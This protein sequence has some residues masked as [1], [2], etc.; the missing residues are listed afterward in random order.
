MMKT[1]FRKKTIV[2][3]RLLAQKLL[4]KYSPKII[5]ITGAVGKTSTREACFTVLSKKFRCVKNYDSKLDDME[6]IPIAIVGGKEDPHGWVD[7]LKMLLMGFQKLFFGSTY[8]DIVIVEIRVKYPGDVKKMYDFL[9]S[10]DVGVL[11]A[12]SDIPSHVEHFNSIDSFAK[13]KMSIITLLPPKAIAVANMDDDRVVRALSKIKRKV[14]TIGFDN[15][16]DYFAENPHVNSDDIFYSGKGTSGISYKLHYDQNSIPIR[17]P[18]IYS[19]HHV[20]PSL[21][22]IVI[23]ISMDINLV[24]IARALTTFEPPRHRMEAL[25]GIKHS[26]IIDDSFNASPASCEAAL[27]TMRLLDTDGKKIAVLADMLELGAETEKAHRQVGKMACE[28]VDCVITYGDRAAFMY[29]EVQKICPEMKCFAHFTD[30][31]RLIDALVEKYLN[32]GDLLLVKGSRMMHMEEVCD[33]L[34]VS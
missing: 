1:F 30:K 20:Y 9:E 7:M 5:A 33:A 12:I 10:V 13:E 3:I 25:K 2:A 8:A 32:E 28:S 21:F 23:G 6:S 11:T 16:A 29:D 4:K 18:H 15:D 34:K 31:K 14:V 22:A 24:D 27:S 17:L 19:I 26:T